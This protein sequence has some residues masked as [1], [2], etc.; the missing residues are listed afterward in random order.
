M[1]I[2]K[3]DRATL[4][5]LRT[6]MQSA[7]EATGIDGV[8]F[9]VGNMRFTEA[10]AT[11]KIVAKTEGAAD[12]NLGQVARMAKLHGIATIEANGWK[13]IEYHAKK[14]KYPFIALSPQFKRFKLSPDQ[15]QN[16]FGVAA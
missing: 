6:A 2:E 5:I 15:A 9:E 13:L 8:T 16:R 3:F 14:R 4:N 12:A 1:K 10:E 11:I 7:L